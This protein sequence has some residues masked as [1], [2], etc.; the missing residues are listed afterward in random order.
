M[1]LAYLEATQSGPKVTLDDLSSKPA[2]TAISSAPVFS[3]N[4]A[5]SRFLPFRGLHGPGIQTWCRQLS[6]QAIR[7][8]TATPCDSLNGSILSGFPGLSLPMG[9]SPEGLPINIQLIAR[10]H[11]EELL[12][13][14]AKTLNSNKP[15]AP[16]NLRPS[17]PDHASFFL[18][19]PSVH[20]VVKAFFVLILL[21]A[22][23]LRA[24]DRLV[25]LPTSPGPYLNLHPIISRALAKFRLRLLRR[26]S[27]CS[28]CPRR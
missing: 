19:G 26:P 3:G 22:Y 24:R 17:N 13:A 14:V 27:F 9:Q 1:F 12:L 20:S 6:G 11:E 7:T 21:P 15:A 2:W 4:S 23:N 8:T 16:G 5:M 10:P 25:V 18:C 28:N